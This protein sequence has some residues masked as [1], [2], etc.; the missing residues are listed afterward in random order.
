MPASSMV[1]DAACTV[2]AQWSLPT[3][4]EYAH[5]DDLRR[6]DWNVYARLEKLFLKL[7][8]D[9]EELQVHVLLDISKS[10]AFGQPEK[11]RYA[12]RLCAALG[13]ITLVNFD[14][15]SVTAISHHL[16]SRLR[17]LRGKGQTNTFFTW[18]QALQAEGVTDFTRVLRDY[19]L[20]ARTP[21]VVIIISDFLADG[22][23]EGLRA[24]V[25]RKF[26]P[27]LI[28]VLSPEEITPAITGDLRLRD[29]ETSETR[30]VSITP[31][32]LSRYRQ[33]L[34]AHQQFLNGLGN[35]YGVNVICTSTTE[36]F[37][38]FVLRYLKIRRI[39]Q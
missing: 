21:G 24:L 3:Y 19:S 20:Y 16:G 2:A 15:L 11:L 7:Y 9:E 29:A 13:Y 25:G 35:R 12:Q 27:T 26:S 38:Q 1:S 4:R 23:E 14:C 36:P 34:Q 30:E 37:D 39:I 5:G 28:Q 32:L 6:L 8:I 33:R 31:N 17:G 18:L 10:M 22:I